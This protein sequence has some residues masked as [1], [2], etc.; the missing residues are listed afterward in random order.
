MTNPQGIPTRIQGD[1]QR[2]RDARTAI[3]IG[4]VAVLAVAIGLIWHAVDERKADEHRDR[5]DRVV[6]VL[7]DNLGHD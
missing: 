4:V 5:V 1:A 2:R 3:G 6:Q 7:E